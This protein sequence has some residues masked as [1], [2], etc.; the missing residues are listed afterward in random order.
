MLA[1]SGTWMGIF[2]ILCG[3][4]ARSGDPLIIEI[5]TCISRF[6]PAIKSFFP[7]KYDDAEST[8]ISG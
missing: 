3:Q 1:V 5:F 4:C 7:L 8:G 2:V 6:F